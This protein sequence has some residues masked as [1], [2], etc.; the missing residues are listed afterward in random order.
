MH[1]ILF[2][3]R[4]D[5]GEQLAKALKKYTEHKNAH[6]V[7]LPRGG[8]FVAAPIAEKLK[9]P[10][11]VLLVHSM[12]HP[13]DKETKIG[14]L[15]ESGIF[16]IDA[17]LSKKLSQVRVKLLIEESKSHLRQRGEYYRKAKKRIPVTGK[18]II[19]IDDGIDTGTTMKTAIES[20]RKEHPE[21]IIVAVPI[22]RAESMKALRPYAEDFICLRKPEQFEGISKAYYDFLTISDEEA[23]RILET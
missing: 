11:D 19:I 1:D 7:A 4:H 5:A 22:T 15:S 14:G 20:I 8:L 3:D 18:T 21:E 2:K 17:A 10:L 16:A 23:L 13:K 6:I 9:L 12:K